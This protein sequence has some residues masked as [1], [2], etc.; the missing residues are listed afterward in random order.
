MEA[1]QNSW[2]SNNVEHDDS[3]GGFGEHPPRFM[4]SAFCHYCASTNISSS[5]CHSICLDCDAVSEGCGD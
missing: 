2:L 3:N 5:G 1:V 4:S